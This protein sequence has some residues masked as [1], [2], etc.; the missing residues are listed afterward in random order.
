MRAGKQR[1]RVTLEP[2]RLPPE[3]R[4]E[5]GIEYIQLLQPIEM[6]DYKGREKELLARLDI[7]VAKCREFGI[8]RM[9]SWADVGQFEKGLRKKLSQ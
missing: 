7:V 9:G 8:S 5:R 4:V 3:R 6:K 2:R 1:G